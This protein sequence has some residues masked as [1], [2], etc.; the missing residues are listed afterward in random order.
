MNTTGANQMTEPQQAAEGEDSTVH[1]WFGQSVARDAEL[2][3]T[4]VDEVGAEK[5]EEI[6][7]DV[8]TGEREQQERRGDQLDPDQGEQEYRDDAAPE[9]AR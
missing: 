6:F 2:A 1:E 4:L 8:A 9:S 5:A 3:D 7:D